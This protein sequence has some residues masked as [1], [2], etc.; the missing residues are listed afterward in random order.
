MNS[1]TKI[2][3]AIKAPTKS[4][5]RKGWVKVVREVDASKDNG[6]AFV[7]DFARDGWLDLPAGAVVLVA[8]HNGSTS[9]K[10]D[11]IDVHVV[12]PEGLGEPVHVCKDVTSPDFFALRAKVAELLPVVAPAGESTESA[13]LVAARAAVAKLSP[14]DLAK[15]LA[16]LTK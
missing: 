5:G 2:R 6:F 14:T 1:S 8:D 16:D 7:G 3:V 9:T 12:G 11:W 4:R 10:P 13:E 15:L